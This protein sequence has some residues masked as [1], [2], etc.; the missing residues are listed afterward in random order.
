MKTALN[1]QVV[2]FHRRDALQYS[3]YGS[4]EKQT[5]QSANII[6]SSKAAV[7]RPRRVQKKSAAA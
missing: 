2:R 5:V 7:W 4:F 6:G 3:G 1:P